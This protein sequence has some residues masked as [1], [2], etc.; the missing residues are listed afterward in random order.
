MPRTVL[1]K[2]GNRGGLQCL[3]PPIP[4]RVIADNT[5]LE[6]LRAP[7]IS[8]T[9]LPGDKAALVDLPKISIKNH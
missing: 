1:M 9:A 4:G 3:T 2:P 6:R 8:W 5:G 7:E